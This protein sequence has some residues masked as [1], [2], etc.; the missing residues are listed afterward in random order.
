[1]T[2][3]HACM[4][5]CKPSSEEVSASEDPSRT[6]TQTSPEAESVMYENSLFSPGRIQEPKPG[7]QQ[8]IRVAEAVE[9]F[10][11][12]ELL[13]S[14]VL[15]DFTATMTTPAL[16]SK[17]FVLRDS[18][19]HQYSPRKN[20]SGKE[21]DSCANGQGGRVAEADDAF[22]VADPPPSPVLSDFTAKM[23][24]PALGSKSFVLRDSVSPK[25]ALPSSPWLQPRSVLVDDNGPGSAHAALPV[26]DA[27]ST[28]P[29]LATEKGSDSPRWSV[30]GFFTARS[31]MTD[32][33][34]ALSPRLLS[35]RVALGLQV[36]PLSSSATSS[37]E[38]VRAS[39]G[40]SEGD[41]EPNLI[42]DKTGAGIAVPEEWRYHPR[43]E[44]VSG[45]SDCLSDSEAAALVQVKSRLTDEMLW[46]IEECRC[47]PGE[48]VDRF[49]LRFLRARAFRISK[50]YAMLHA[51]L[52]WRKTQNV[53]TLV[54]RTPEEITG[55]GLADLEKN[56][57]I[58]TQGNDKQGRPI[59]YKQ[60]GYM[61]IKALVRMG[62]S[63][64]QMVQ[65]HIW[66][67]EASVRLLAKQ[68]AKLGL[69][70]ETFTI[71]IDAK[72]WN[73]SRGANLTG[74]SYM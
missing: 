9:E 60:F 55:V 27:S 10:A 49:I 56:V 43:W 21:L 74:I 15:S 28:A 68:T 71:I 13:P 23:N 62:G 51:H 70:V 17:S 6:V 45:Y 42:M 65:Y 59:I 37:N 16:G 5:V 26:F 63:V 53:K 54:Q 64:E 4:R 29:L 7:S 48:T 1:M 66:E 52:E 50:T 34:G 25:N 67:T 8:G 22:A 69:Y 35:P 57:A 40:V 44:R 39:N 31:S 36:S 11:A 19:L 41:H 47:R 3:F 46:Q 14:P 72:G 12:V 61:D 32:L 33:E 30:D 2:C 38:L 73:L 58:W 18:V 24:S 20:A